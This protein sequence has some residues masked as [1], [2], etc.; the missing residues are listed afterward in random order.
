MEIRSRVVQVIL[1]GGLVLTGG[2]A[3][4][5]SAD[6]PGGGSSS[7]DQY[8]PPSSPNGGNPQGGPDNNCG[9]PPDKCPDGSP[10]PPPGNCGKPPD[11]CPDG[12][13]KPP[14]GNCGHGA[15]ANG[16]NGSGKPPKT[17]QSGSEGSG[18]PRKAKVRVHRH[19]R[20]GCITSTFSA[21]ISVSN[22]AKGR[23]IVVY[24]DGRR[25]KSS[26][27]PAFK[28]R[29]DVRRLSRGVHTVKIRVRGADGHTVTKVLHF[30][31][32]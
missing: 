31:R 9:N 30:R 17:P 28:V 22:K 24:R 13:P 19:P 7:K 4:L 3:V 27:K 29:F 18:K 11:T 8:C 25:I 16:G 6:D 14:P 15:I 2:G 20:K 10:K 1:V 12:T 5:A 32:C 23:K 21:R 26:G